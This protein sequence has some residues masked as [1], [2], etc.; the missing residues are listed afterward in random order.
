MQTWH[1]VCALAS[2]AWQ[3]VVGEALAKQLRPS[4]DFN[5]EL[6]EL[7]GDA[8]RACRGWW[9]S[10]SRTCRRPASART[11]ES[12]RAFR[13]TVLP[14]APGGGTSDGSVRRTS[15]VWRQREHVPLCPASRTSVCTASRSSASVKVVSSASRPWTLGIQPSAPGRRGGRPIFPDTCALLPQTPAACLLLR[16][17][18]SSRKTRSSSGASDGRYTRTVS[19]TT[20]S[21]TSK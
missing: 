21:S 8:R 9:P 11:L 18:P 14:A 16:Q 2:V 6:P 15:T 20:M 4:P 17:A 7:D 3:A 1:D 5:Q 10:S 19:K 12:E 13:A